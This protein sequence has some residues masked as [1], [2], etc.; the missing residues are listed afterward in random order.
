MI[1]RNIIWLAIVAYIF[2]MGWA[3]NRYS[4]IRSMGEPQ[5]EIFV[6]SVNKE[7]LAE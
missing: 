7:Q 5:V 6:V 3:S 4:G 2:A 1:R